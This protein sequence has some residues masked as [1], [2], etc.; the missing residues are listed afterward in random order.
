MRRGEARHWAM[1]SGGSTLCRHWA[2]LNN[3]DSGGYIGQP[4]AARRVFCYA[5]CACAGH[6]LRAPHQLCR[7][8]QIGPF[9]CGATNESPNT[10]P[11]DSY[12]E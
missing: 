10:Q 9:G 2:E 3:V 8:T 7:A 11:S 5:Q 1:N 4:M 6:A 12:N